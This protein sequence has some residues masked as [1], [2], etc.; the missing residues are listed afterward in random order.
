[1]VGIP[2][3][4]ISFASVAPQR[5]LVPQVEV[6]ITPDTPSALRLS[7]IFLP[8]LHDFHNARQTGSAIEPVV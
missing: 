1:M 4:S 8:C 5:V 7:A 2:A 3:L 6:R